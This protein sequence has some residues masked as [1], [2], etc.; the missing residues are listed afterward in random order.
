MIQAPLIL[1]LLVDRK[2]QTIQ[3]YSWSENKLE[4][5]AGLAPIE[6]MCSTSSNQPYSFQNLSSSI[7]L[8]W[9]LQTEKRAKIAV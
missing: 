2:D 4:D 7:D 5:I 6:A 3:V 1:M 8:G 9:K